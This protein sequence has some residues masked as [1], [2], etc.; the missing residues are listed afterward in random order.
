MTAPTRPRTSPNGR[1]PLRAAA[2]VIRSKSIGTESGRE[3]RRLRASKWQE[4]AIQ[5]ATDIGEIG[6]GY[7]QKGNAAAKVKL[8]VAYRPERDAE[9]ISA[10]GLTGFD[11]ANAALDRLDEKS[12]FGLPGILR[13]MVLNL[14]VA[15]EAYL[16]GEP[17]DE[18]GK[19]LDP[20]VTNGPQ[21]G[22]GPDAG[23]DDDPDAVDERWDVRSVLE[24]QRD[25]DKETLRERQGATPRPLGRGAYVARIWSPSPYY[26]DEAWSAMRWVLER[27]DEFMLLSRGVR[28]L[29]RSRL[30]AGMLGMPQ[31][32]TFRPPTP[33]REN[34]A[35]GED[36]S[37]EEMLLEVMTAAIE[38]EGSASSV[39]PILAFLPPDVWKEF[40]QDKLVNF[41]RPLQKELLDERDKLRRWIME[42]LNFPIESVTGSE[43]QNHWNI[44]F[45]WG[46]QFPLYTEPSVQLA[47][48]GLTTGFLRPMLRE[49]DVDAAAANRLLVW[50]DPSALVVQPN[51]VKDVFTAA[52]LGAVGLRTVREAIGK[53]DDDAPTPEELDIMRSMKGGSAPTSGT[54]IGTPND[55]EPP[56]DTAEAESAV[57][58]AASPAARKPNT[59]GRRLLAIDRELRARLEAAATAAMNR[60]LERAG[61][62]I[63]NRMAKASS[64]A[65]VARTAG[66]V[67]IG[68]VHNCAVSSTLGRPMVAALGF[69]EGELVE[70]A[71][72]DFG[73]QFDSWV[74]RAQGQ[75]LAVLADDIDD[76]EAEELAARQA[77]DRSAAWGW[78]SETLLAT[79]AAR[80]YDPSPSAPAPGEFDSSLAVPTGVIRE[81]MARAGGAHGALMAD[82]PA[83][84]VATGQLV[85]LAL[86]RN[87][88]T[89][90]GWRWVYGG[91]DVP[92]AGHEDLDDAEFSSWT[93]D[94]LRVQAGDEW[95]GPYYV[96]GDHPGCSC[97]FEPI[98][99]ET[100]EAG[101]DG[102][103]DAEAEAA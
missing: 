95:I 84:G 69:G 64:S 21:F 103:A 73:D 28:G 5:C 43:N 23:V 50:Y 16:V 11:Q 35:D 30:M 27:C 13:E 63:R 9:P 26:S 44:W 24:Y 29:A 2:E 52:G 17:L 98:W 38:D 77:D 4:D 54:S 80:L 96:T 72:D 82:G 15:G 8:F 85:Q 92:F 18:N 102:A 10:E 61:A 65:S 93:D 59:L 58:A 89:L 33:Q 81:A 20:T 47:C 19:T 45:L 3:G 101:D 75:S 88:R 46:S 78:L 76:A 99:S 42:T 62:R 41:V 70:D 36:L 90:E 31:G 22:I 83:G 67:A 25:K 94:L 71:L 37:P 14:D 66:A 39:V 48:H 1:G 87:G 86:G 7:D 34:D 53:G 6:E 79:A 51:E 57:T 97:D 68:E 100:G 60:A 32:T 55:G 56:D 49:A 91:S 12:P 74:T 40:G